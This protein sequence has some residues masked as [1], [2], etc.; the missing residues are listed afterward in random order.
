VQ[1][2]AVNRDEKIQIRSRESK[3]LLQLLAKLNTSAISKQQ[4]KLN[5]SSASPSSDESTR[6]DFVLLH[7]IHFKF[8]IK[9]RNYCSLFSYFLKGTS[10]VR[11]RLRF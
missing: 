2:L 6:S 1:F 11:S 9:L 3:I 10:P 8:A 4:T 7:A 5:M